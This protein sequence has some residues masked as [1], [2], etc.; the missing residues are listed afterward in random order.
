M[1]EAIRSVAPESL[2]RYPPPDAAD[3]RHTAACVHGLTP[4]QVIATNGG[5]ELL[6]LAITVFCHPRRDAQSDRAPG[7]V[8]FTD[9]TY[10][11]YPVL[12]Q[13][14]DTPVTRVPLDDGFALPDGFADRLN[15]T[16]CRLALIVNPHA[17]SG[18]LR[19][20]EQLQAIAETF[21]GVLLIDEAYT[22][23]ASHDA[24][25]L[26]GPARGLDNVLILRSLSKGYSLAG[27]RFGYGMGHPGLIAALH[28]ARD[29]YNTDV[30]AQAA[31]TAALTHRD[32]AARTWEAVIGERQRLTAALTQR[33][34]AVIPSQSNFLLTTPPPSAP[35][36]EVHQSLKDR[37]VFV[38]YFD[39]PRLDDKL[40]ITVGTAEENDR[41]LSALDGLG[42]TTS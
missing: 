15:A 20:I 28:K 9:P 22:D 11:L 21:D 12:A 36:R 31:A 34:C 26:L 41:L 16:G 1:I 27:L 18:L 37:G 8:G 2:R 23:F 5:D 14:H 30:L 4:D 10:S 13:I 6:R 19:P 32:L 25:P 35:A 42:L 17:P 7:G 33:R 24:L 40:R 39:Q 3:F 38:R 29:S